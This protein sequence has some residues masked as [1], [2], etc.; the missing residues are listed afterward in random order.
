MRP[1]GPRSEPTS[2]WGQE[3]NSIC[4][5][6]DVRTD[7]EAIAFHRGTSLKVDNIMPRF[8]LFSFRCVITMRR[9]RKSARACNWSVMSTGFLTAK[10]SA[11]GYIQTDRRIVQFGDCR[12]TRF[13]W[14]INFLTLN[15]PPQK[16]KHSSIDPQWRL[17]SSDKL[18][19]LI[20]IPNPPM[21]S[22]S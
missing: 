13:D 6:G 15:P 22:L 21:R 7:L 20:L 10:R 14:S 5:L 8:C 11:V 1:T 12:L 16:Q 2:P 3:E 18:A 4:P 17:V 9:T 19:T